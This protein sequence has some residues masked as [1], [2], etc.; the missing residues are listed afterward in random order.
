MS[1]QLYKV[2]DEVEFKAQLLAKYWNNFYTEISEHLP[3][4]YQPEM[5]ELSI[6][7]DKALS[8]LVDE[9]RNPT[10]TLA[11][12]GT[13]SSGKSTLVNL[14]CGAEIVPVAVS[15]MSAGAVTIEYSKEK[16]LIIHETPG[17]LWECGEWRGIREE[18]IYQRLYEAMIS[19]IENREKQPNL[20][21]PQSTIFYPFRLV[22]ES[23][24]ELPQGTRVK[25]LDLPGLAYVGDQG[26]AN[27]IQ[28]C[29]EALCIVT[30]NSAETDAQKVKSLLQEV[31]QQV[32]DLGGS[33]A[34]MLFTLNRIDV[35]RSDRNW[36]E[37]ENRFFENAIRS[38]KGELTEQL[39]EYTEE[40]EKLQVVKL[41][42][43]PALLALQIQNYDEI[44]S[45]EACKKAD[46]N[47]NG[48][49][50]EDIL[51]DLPRNVQKWSRHDR[52]RVAEAL[53]KKS[54]AEEFQQ[55][56][57]EHITEHFPQLVIPQIIERFNLAAGNAVT[58]WAVQTTTAILNSSEA[59]Y[60]EEC[61]KISKIRAEL[62]GFLETSDTNL[63]QPFERLDTKVKQVLA[64][65][66]Q[67]DVVNY[68]R[69]VIREL[70]Q[71][72]PYKKLG[73]K[74]FPLY[75]WE[76]EFQKG[77]TQVLEAVAKSLE[78]GRVELDSPNLKRAN[79]LNVNLLARNLN[80]LVDLGY[81][82]SVAKEGKTMEARTEADKNKLKQLNEELNELAIHLN[83][84]I[85]D[86]L[87]QISTQE[88]NRIHQAVSELFRCHLSYFE[89]EANDIAP[90]IAIKFPE[91]EL[92]KIESNLTFNF[93]FKAG[94]AI[95]K[96]TWK[97]AVQVE[98][99][100]RTW[101]T[102]WIG[103]KTI[104]ETEYQQRSSD[105]AELP[106]IEYLLTGWIEQAKG[107]ESERVNQVARWLLEQIDCLKKNVDKI[108]SDI[109]D[110]YQE[111]LD[112]ANQEITLDYEKQ[113]NIWQPMEQKA[114]SLAE[115]FSSLGK[116]WKIK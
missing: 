77:I 112:K 49:I 114:Q 37:T 9:L 83:I 27:V 25:I 3:D 36:P 65:Q 55:H 95:T 47:F 70:Q 4:T 81:K 97:E 111:R 5:Q 80:R 109:I 87:K 15:E 78:T 85:Q 33:P 16:S 39:K 92:I 30:Y 102:L 106:S 72:E 2:F 98:K 32:K 45:A 29:R 46:N 74:L 24:L 59:G 76:K 44:F 8:N 34:R 11:T 62:E 73:E 82:A 40:I 66:S 69:T 21:C 108:Q 64:K 94:F 12:T 20:A 14:L 60:Q 61:E 58:E 1:K 35:F 22:K 50:D 115:E 19:Y 79:V 7:L 67:D 31:V 53:W 103:K 41:S 68:I 26:N 23:K 54:Y 113:R 48:L 6:K 52:N 86:V 91:S 93:R 57:R 89:N 110:R 42:T 104:Y 107:E 18:K 84:V 43:W 75:S 71:E 28:Q 96:G 100:K 13:T 105:N 90:N 56:L 88:L 51:E 99:Q 10:L 63:K 101:Y 17:A 38:I 116:I